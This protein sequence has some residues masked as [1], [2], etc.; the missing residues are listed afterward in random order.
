MIII[1][2]KYFYRVK[3]LVKITLL[4]LKVIIILVRE[5]ID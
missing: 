3:T 4:L 2:K 5:F 1:V